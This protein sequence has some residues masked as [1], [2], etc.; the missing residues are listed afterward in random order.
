[1]TILPKYQ[2]FWRRFWAGWIDTAIFLP[3]LY[4][5]RWVWKNFSQQPLALIPWFLFSNVV[6]LAYSIL[7]HGFWGQTVGKRLFGIRVLDVSEAKLSLMQ[8]ALRDLFPLV[9]L[10][11]SVVTDLPVVARGQHAYDQAKLAHD[12]IPLMALLYGYA[13]MG[14]SIAELATML[15]NDKRR[16]VHDYIA[17]SVVVRDPLL[18]SAETPA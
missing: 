18:R 5:D 16:A 11:V 9:L 15:F 3:L 7:C 12:G 8:A 14:W 13:M 10:A 6:G 1:V 2:T 4:V 17:R